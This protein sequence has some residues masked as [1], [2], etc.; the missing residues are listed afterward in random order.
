MLDEFAEVK[1][2]GFSEKRR[3]M[4]ALFKRRLPPTASEREIG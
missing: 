3:P 4:L 1:F 2:L